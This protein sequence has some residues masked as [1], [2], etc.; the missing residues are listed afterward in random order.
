MTA[1]SPMDIRCSCPTY[2]LLKSLGLRW[3][4]QAADYLDE[5]GNLAAFDPTAHEDGPSALLIREDLLREYLS[6]EGLVLCW[7]VLGEKWVIGPMNARKYHGSLK[8]SGAY[9]YTDQGPEGDLN[10]NPDIPSDET[11]T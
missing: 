2:R 3:S 6:K 9:R 1:Q 8:I 10:F 11:A 5:D 7:T 4:G